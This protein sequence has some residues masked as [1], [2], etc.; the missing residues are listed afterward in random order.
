MASPKPVL[1]K[2]LS[3]KRELG[4]FEITL[5]GV[6]IILGAGIY[7]LIGQAAGLAGTSVWLAFAISA[8]MALFTGLSYAELSSM[9]P[10]AGAEY[11]Y[12][13]HAFSQQFASIIGWLVFLSGVLAAA[14][15]ALGF[16]GYFFALTGTPLTVSAI[17][18]IVL[19]AIILVH[20][21]KETAWVAIIATL[22]EMAGLV[23]I[24]AIGAPHLG[25]M[26]YFEMPHGLHGLFAASALIFFAYQGFESMVK[27]AEETRDP[28]TTIPRALILAIAVSLVLYI[29]VA[30]SVVSVLDWQQLAVSEAPF[31][32]I[33][34]GTLGHDAAVIITVIALFATANTVLMSMYASSRILYGMAGSSLLLPRIL[35][36]VD[37][38]TRTPWIAIAVCG[39]LSAGFLFAGDIAFVA[40]VTNFTLFVTFIVINAAVIALRYRA[41]QIA[42]PF[43]IPLAIGALPVLPV[44]GL[45]FCIFLL[46][47]QDWSVL[48][49]GLGLTLTGVPFTLAGTGRGR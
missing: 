48:A 21:V 5:S 8:V 18:L 35:G 1:Q 31:A 44:A 7:V 19:L 2:S 17:A 16:A 28:E 38:R 49:L 26:D 27:F 12:V 47:Q 39:L 43:K 42:R 4:L 23:I 45:V 9:F 32:D 15:V 46:F 29:L 40:N 30:L 41:P 20:G 11:D 25:S 10:K 13:E 3:L 6:G 22:I 36:R 14:T 37:D 33:V 34:S 24:I